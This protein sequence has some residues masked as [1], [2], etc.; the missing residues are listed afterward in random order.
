MEENKG[1]S[2]ILS[3]GHGHVPPVDQVGFLLE[4]G[5]E[6][7]LDLV[8]LGGAFLFLFLSE[9]RH[10]VVEQVLTLRT[11]V[12]TLKPLVFASL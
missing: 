6:L 12:D 11:L 2:L 8:S 1:I 3:V 10:V 7:L 5:H 9:V 4:K